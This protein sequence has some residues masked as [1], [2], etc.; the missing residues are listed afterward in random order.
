MLYSATSKVCAEVE[1]TLYQSFTESAASHKDTTII[2]LDGSA[3][4]LCGRGREFI[5]QHSHGKVSDTAIAI[6][7]VV[8]SSSGASFG[9]ND[10]VVFL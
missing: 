6:T 7:V 3:D 4:N 2:V 5:N 9:I 1:A 8:H 10:E